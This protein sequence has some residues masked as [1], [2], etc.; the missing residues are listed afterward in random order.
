M[1]IDVTPQ[2]QT[3]GGGG[4]QNHRQ[5]WRTP[6]IERAMLRLYR[7]ARE[8]L[9]RSVSARRRDTLYCSARVAQGRRRIGAGKNL[10]AETTT[11]RTSHAR[12]AYCIGKGQ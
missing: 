6:G 9:Y 5:A 12:R 1:L 11:R 2:S 7:K 10:A 8:A 3:R 4:P